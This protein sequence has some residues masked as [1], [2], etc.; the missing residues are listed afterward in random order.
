MTS[1]R[2]SASSVTGPAISSRP[3]T[4]SRSASSRVHARSRS[5][6]G[7]IIGGSIAIPG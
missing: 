6:S 5:R 4:S 1:A 2:A 7:A 3:R